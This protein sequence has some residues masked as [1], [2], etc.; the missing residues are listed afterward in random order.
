MLR[1]D[2]APVAGPVR[3]ACLRPAV[4]GC[5]SNLD[6]GADPSVPTRAPNNSTTPLMV[7]IDAVVISNA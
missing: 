5:A 1:D 2:L 7:N 4:T 3:L 6:L